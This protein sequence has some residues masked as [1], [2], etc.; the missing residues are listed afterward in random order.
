VN[1]RPKQLTRPRL[2]AALFLP[3][4]LYVV[5]RIVTGSAIE[6]LALTE[7]IPAAGLLFAGIRRRHI[8]AIGVLSTVTVAIALATYALTGDDPLALKLRHG[9]VTGMFGIALLASLALGRPLPVVLVE[10]RAEL[11]SE[12]RAEI[13]ARLADPVRRRALAVMTLLVGLAM[14]LDGAVQTT[15]AL[16]VSTSA[17]VAAST[18]AHIIILGGGAASLVWY[19]RYRY[20]RHQRRLGLD[21]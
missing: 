17:F 14:T 21:R 6:A 9:A 12:R 19:S 4:G 15:L 16:T 13:Q 10:R 8:D 18:I 20:Q 5:L 7:A 1:A 11:D 2:L 3:L